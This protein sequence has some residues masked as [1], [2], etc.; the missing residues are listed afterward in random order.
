MFRGLKHWSV[1]CGTCTGPYAVVGAFL[2]E[3]ALS[4][5]LAQM[6]RISRITDALSVTQSS[7]LPLAATQTPAHTSGAR[8]AL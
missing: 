4:A 2:S 1:F 5:A 7:P 3:V 8:W 6:A